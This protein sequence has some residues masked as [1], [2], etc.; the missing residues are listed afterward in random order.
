MNE[1]IITEID[2][3]CTVYPNLSTCKINVNNSI[4][5]LMAWFLIFPSRKP[6]VNDSQ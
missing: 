3:K 2:E 6:E 4:R 1:Q 5:L